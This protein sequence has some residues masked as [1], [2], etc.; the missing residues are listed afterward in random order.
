[1]RHAVRWITA[2]ALLVGTGGLALTVMYSSN[3]AGVA[4]A[5][6]TD[7][8]VAMID[9]AITVGVVD[10]LLK[11]YSERQRV[12]SITPRVMELIQKLEKLQGSQKRYLHNASPNDLERYR[13]AVSETERAT[14]DLHILMAESHSVLASNLLRLSH[15][16]VEHLETIEDAMTALRN[17]ASDSNR[18]VDEVASQSERLFSDGSGLTSSLRSE[19]HEERLLPQA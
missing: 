10:L 11:S 12:K 6:A 18:W 15:D 1:M 2:L 14:F 9:L 5:I 17:K 4:E 19:F 7:F 13:R 3:R 16:M 8:S